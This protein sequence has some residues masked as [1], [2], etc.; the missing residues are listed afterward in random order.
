MPNLSASRIWNTQTFI[1]KRLHNNYLPDIMVGIRKR[2]TLYDPARLS[3]AAILLLQGDRKLRPPRSLTDNLG[4]LLVIK[5]YFHPPHKTRKINVASTCDSA[6]AYFLGIL[7]TLSLGGVSRINRRAN[8][9]GN[10]QAM[11][12]IREVRNGNRPDVVRIDGS[13]GAQPV[14][15]ATLGHCVIPK[16]PASA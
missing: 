5:V 9:L 13:T 11:L 8:F 14:L 10:F 1:V 3:L 4:K 16:C 6:T 7:S 12:M 15:Q 2:C